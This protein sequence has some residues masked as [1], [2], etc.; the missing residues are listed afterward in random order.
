MFGCD[1]VD[2][3]RCGVYDDGMFFDS[4]LDHVN[5]FLKT[6]QPCAQISYVLAVSFTK[7]LKH[8]LAAFTNI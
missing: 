8:L 6:E 7:S 2:R 3:F 4:V 1:F 5:F